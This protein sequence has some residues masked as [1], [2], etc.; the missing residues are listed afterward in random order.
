MPPV[1]PVV[2]APIRLATREVRDLVPLVAKLR[3][4]T[5]CS[6]EVR[7]TIVFPGFQQPARVPPPAERRPFVDRQFVAGDVVR[8]ERRRFV[9]RPKPPPTIET[10]QRVDEVD[11]HR[12]ETRLPRPFDARPRRR[13][14]VPPAE[15][16]ERPII[17]RLQPQADPVETEFPPPRQRLSRGILRIH[18]D[19]PFRLRTNRERRDQPTPNHPKLVHTQ[20]RRS[21]TPEVHR[22]ETAGPEPLSLTRPTPLSPPA[23]EEVDLPNQGLHKPLPIRLSTTRHREVTVRTDRRAER[24]VDVE[25]CRFRHNRSADHDRTLPAIEPLRTHPADSAPALFSLASRT[26]RSPQRT[27]TSSR[28]GA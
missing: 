20:R 12:P 24:D 8:L 19:R 2:A 17:Q 9:Q 1:L 5:V 28:R 23:T 4:A 25:A 27:T 14:I 18:L 16:A 21:T 6:H 26:A 22:V 11:R 7:G 3:E 10:R 15:K 13:R